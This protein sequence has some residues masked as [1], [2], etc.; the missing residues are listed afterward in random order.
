MKTFYGIGMVAAIAPVLFSLLAL[1]AGCRDEYSLTPAEELV[2]RVAQPREDEFQAVLCV[3][4]ADVLTHN[5]IELSLQTYGSVM[6]Q[7]ADKKTKKVT[8]SA[9]TAARRYCTLLIT[10]FEFTSPIKRVQLDLTREDAGIIGVE[11]C[12]WT[13][14]ST[15]VTNVYSRKHAPCTEIKPYRERLYGISM[16]QTENEL[17]D[18]FTPVL[19]GRR[20]ANS[21]TLIP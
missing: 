12:T 4:T 2:K 11:I 20:D 7:W 14:A 1:G 5:T 16:L 6:A 8:F 19:V 21:P 18:N 15:P 9:A 3:V 17:F 10:E 13:S